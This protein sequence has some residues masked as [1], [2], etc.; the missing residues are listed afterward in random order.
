MCSSSKLGRLL[1]LS[2]VFLHNGLS[3]LWEPDNSGKDGR[4]LSILFAGLVVSSFPAV[5]WVLIDFLDVARGLHPE[6]YAIVHH[7][8]EI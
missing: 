1:P 7:A 8:N 6:K 4:L 3:I 5:S 2:L